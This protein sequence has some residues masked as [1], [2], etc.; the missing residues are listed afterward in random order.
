MLKKLLL[1]LLVLVSYSIIGQTIVD[2]HGRLRVQ[3]NKIVDKNQNPVSIAGNSLFWSNAGDTADF[4]NSQTVNF[5][6]DNWNSSVIRVAMGVNEPWD[7]GRG[8][9]NSPNAQETKIRRVIDAAIAKGIYVIID[10]HTHEAEQYTDEAV[11][12]F[13]KMARIYGDEPNVI[14]EIYNEPVNQSWNTIKNYAE[15]VIDGIRSEDPNNLIIVGTPFY[16]QRVDIASNNPINDNNTAYT[17]HFYAGTHGNDLRNKAR[18]AMNNGIALFVTE[19]GT[20]NADGNGNPDNSSTQTWMNFLR[21]ND[22]S[23]ANWAVSD[24]NEGASIVRS[25]RGIN[26]LR[27]GQLTAS[28]NLVRGI[29]RNWRPDEPN[30]NDNNSEVNWVTPSGN[31]TVQQGYSSLQLEAVGNV[32]GGNI[33]H[34]SL[35]IDGNKIRDERVAPYTWGRGSNASETL[36]LGVGTHNVRARMVANNGD[37]YND[38]FTLTVTRSSNNRRS[39]NFVTPSGNLTLPQG[40]GRLELEAVGNVPGGSIDRMSLLIDGR[41]VRHENIAPYNW[42]IGNTRNETRGLSVGTH[43]IRVILRDNNGNFTADRFTLTVTRNRNATDTDAETP[44]SVSLIGQTSVLE[45]S[46]KVYPNPANNEIFMEGL[47]NK[48]G[49]V[50]IVD[51]LGRTVIKR[52]IGPDDYYIDI[53]T[54]SSSNYII[55]FVYDDIVISKKLIK[56][57]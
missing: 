21:N 27:N 24:K 15:E 49:Q 56:T 4:Y 6:A 44:A 55:Q 13:T 38:T 40:Y 28:G 57:K 43:E 1:S 45:E 31:L 5:L 32:A 10:W 42:G 33:R 12:F 2:A 52:E 36:G 19:W 46:I 14:Y 53:S 3:G 54:L 25:G 37:V 34:I 18:T 41:F 48:E 39:V 8:Y 9:I 35:F 26:G 17:L 23:H 50:Q 11:E 22:I 30:Q 51:M 47:P 16:S 20:V 29:I 7:N